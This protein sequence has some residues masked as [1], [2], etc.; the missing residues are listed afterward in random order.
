MAKRDPLLIP[1]RRARFNNTRTR[2]GKSI[3]LASDSKADRLGLSKTADALAR[4]GRRARWGIGRNQAAD[5]RVVRG[6]PA[7][8][9]EGYRLAITP[10]G[11]TISARTD[12]GAF[13]G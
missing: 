4:S 3:M 5:V 9:E 8:H 11:V 6:G 12:A 7:E 10:E 13:Y 1:P 2:L